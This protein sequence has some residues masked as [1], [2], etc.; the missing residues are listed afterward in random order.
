MERLSQPCQP[1][2]AA[3]W[4][5]W[6]GLIQS[7]YCDDNLTLETV[8]TILLEDYNF[9]AMERQYKQKVIEWKLSKNIKD[10]DMRVMLWVQRIRREH[11]NK[12]SSF[13]LHGRPVDLRNLHRFCQQKGEIVISTP[14]ESYTGSRKYTESRSIC[15]QYLSLQ[16]RII[17]HVPRP[18]KKCSIRSTRGLPAKICRERASKYRVEAIQGMKTLNSRGL[19]SFLTWTLIRLRLTMSPLRVFPMDRGQTVLQKKL[20]TTFN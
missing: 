13:F 7:L 2:S 5:K 14:R 18:P 9:D 15:F 10:D 1:H 16:C 4:E 11:E 20:S 17:S 6:R 12:E 8:K 19:H 3:E